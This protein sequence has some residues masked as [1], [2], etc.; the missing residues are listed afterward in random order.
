MKITKISNV[1]LKLNLKD[2]NILKKL[3]NGMSNHTFLISKNN[4][5]LVLR[6]PDDNNTTMRNYANE[7]MAYN[8]LKG[9]NITIDYT[10]LDETYGYK[11]SP[12]IK[13]SSLD[14]L[15]LTEEIIKKVITKLKLLHKIDHKNK[16]IKKDP[17]TKI[18]SNLKKVNNIDK[19]YLII[20]DYA[21]KLQDKYLNDNN[22]LIHGDMQL[23]N[24][25][26]SSNNDIYLIDLEYIMVG[27]IYTD[28]AMLSNEVGKKIDIDILKLYFTNP[29]KI[30]Y[31]I[32]NI[33]YLID[34][35]GW[36]LVAKLKENITT[37]GHDFSKIAK[38]Y[39]NIIKTCYNKIKD[40]ECK[41]S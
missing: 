30:Q 38:N 6:I 24:I 11:I 19:E 37:L 29:K 14:N 35:L 17:F 18:E 34:M 5:K 28:L 1:L 26:L 23:S 36:Y 12:Y 13:G 40:Y 10:L 15:Y 39:L 21:K 8:L 31:H 7:I 32:L 41:R 3:T 2:Y 9:K 4:E 22:Y 25:I 27:S 16:I 20:K 33:A